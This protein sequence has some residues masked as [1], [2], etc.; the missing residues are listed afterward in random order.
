M[1][2]LTE[3]ANQVFYEVYVSSETKFNHFEYDHVTYKYV[4]SRINEGVFEAEER[5]IITENFSSEYKR[6]S[7][8]N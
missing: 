7:F 2:V 8:M 1:D 4:A 6:E 5:T 3:L